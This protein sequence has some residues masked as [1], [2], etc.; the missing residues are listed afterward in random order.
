MELQQ[1]QFSS[2]TFV[3][4]EAILRELSAKVTHQP[5]A[6]DL[7]DDTGGSDA[8]AD[9]ITLDD[10]RLRKWKRYHRQTV[11]Q[12]VVGRF[13]QRFDRQA[14]RAVACA[15]NVDPIDL[16]GINNTNSPSDFG[17]RD[18]FAIDFLA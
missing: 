13:D 8:Q 17:M 18:E 2:V 16:D 3:L 14:H 5:V 9:A 7:G 10:S 15:Q 1:M 11:D 12:D 4:G 6:R